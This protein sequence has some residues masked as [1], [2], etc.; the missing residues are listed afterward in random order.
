MAKIKTHTNP[1]LTLVEDNKA[2]WNTPAH[3]RHGFHNLHKI[4]RYGL[5]L[6]SD[7]VLTL[8]E[9]IDSSISEIPGV[10]ELTESQIF[11]AMVVLKDQSVL[12][13]SYAP[14][15]DADH[16]HTIMSITKIFVN[17]M[18]GEMVAAGEIDL[19]K[20]MGFYLPEIGSGYA[21]ATIQDIMDM[22]IENEYSEDYGDP[23]TSSYGQE[24][25]IGWRLPNDQEK[26]LNMFEFLS[27]IKSND[28]VNHSGL[29]NYKSAN[30]D[31]LGWM[32]E[33]VGGKPLRQWVLEIIEAVGIEGTFYCSTD[34]N[35]FPVADGGGCMSARDLARIGLLF[36]RRGSGVANRNVGDK[37]FIENTR[38]RPRIPYGPPR[39]W[40]GYSNQMFTNGAWV[41]HGGYGGQF[42][43][44]D[45]NTGVSCAF[46]SVLENTSGFD[47]NYA[48]KLIKMLEDVAGQC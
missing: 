17:L 31:V 20:T 40:M 29:V 28:L 5:L 41:G 24:S 37:E 43:L 12:Y 25:T 6:R 3:R 4:N 30:T 1:D 42:L 27:N 46:Y 21:K 23:F 13:E 26:H 19:D 32:V 39:E 34:R 33:R 22:N 47:V 44:T 7:H 14:D 16:P 15:F 10:K 11:S 38:N 8:D 36:A 48:A 2:R 35:G 9:K 45:L 18:A